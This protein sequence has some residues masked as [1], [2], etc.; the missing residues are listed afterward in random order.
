MGRREVG[1]E[2]VYA[3]STK[4]RIRYDTHGIVVFVSQL[5]SAQLSSSHRLALL[6]CCGGAR[7]LSPAVGS[8]PRAGLAGHPLAFAA[9][10]R[11]SGGGG[12][13][14]LSMFKER[15]PFVILLETAV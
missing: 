11:A 6:V 3:R 5:S 15:A 10:F 9:I 1:G 14:S 8:K 7:G 4:V 2:I 13:L 12:D